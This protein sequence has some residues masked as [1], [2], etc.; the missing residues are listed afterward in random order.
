MRLN[1]LN[2]CVDDLSEA[3]HF[4]E[5]FFDFQFLKQKGK[6]LVIMSDENGFILVLSDPKAFKGQKTI[7]YP[8]AFHIGFLVE[9]S[10]EV[11][12]AYNRLVAGGIE[13]DKEPYTMRGSSYGFY[14]TVF[15][16]LLIEVSCLVYKDGKKVSKVNDTPLT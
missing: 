14:F 3:R 8:E 4:F 15:N 5:T 1:H 11:D 10:S 2:L 7:R 13:I 16:G 9:T 6:A 12:Q